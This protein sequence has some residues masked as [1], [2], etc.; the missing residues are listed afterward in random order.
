M[1]QS[2]QCI[3]GIAGN[4]V[5]GININV[6]MFFFFST[7]KKL[8]RDFYIAFCICFMALLGGDHLFHAH[9]IVC[10]TLDFLIAPVVA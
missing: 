4:A 9:M 1:V 10:A 2:R 8:V 7:L 3:W 6:K 5:G